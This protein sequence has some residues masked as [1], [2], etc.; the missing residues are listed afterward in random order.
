[1]NIPHV[2]AMATK[3]VNNS[4][5]AGL[6]I[7]AA[8]IIGFLGLIACCIGIFFTFVYALS[9]EAAAAAWFERIQSA[10]AAPGTP[11]A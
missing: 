5:V 7:F 11:A 1:M 2:W 3:N 9:V 4:I 6:V 10:P 8:G